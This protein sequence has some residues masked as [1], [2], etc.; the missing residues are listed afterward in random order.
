MFL[1]ALACI[2]LIQKAKEKKTTPE[3]KQN[4]YTFIFTSR[5]KLTALS[6]LTKDLPISQTQLSTFGY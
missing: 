5:F 1:N 4:W 6:D 2:E 3:T